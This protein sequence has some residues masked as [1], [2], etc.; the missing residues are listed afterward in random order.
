[1]LLAVL[2]IVSA[3][4]GGTGTTATPPAQTAEN[5]APV[6][7]GTDIPTKDTLVIG[8]A[9]FIETLDPLASTGD[10]NNALMQVYAFLTRMGEDGTPKLDLAE[11]MDVSEDGLTM[12]FVLKDA[13]FSNGDPITA[14]DVVFTLNRC[15]ESAYAKSNY[16]TVESFEAVDAKTVVIHLLTPDRTLPY[17]LATSNAGILNKASVEAAGDDYFL[18]PVASGPYKVESWVPGEKITFVA[19]ENYFGGPCAIKKIEWVPITDP[20]TM[21]IALQSGDID[22]AGRYAIDVSSQGVVESDPNLASTGLATASLI[23]LGFNTQKAPFDNPAVRQAISKAINKEE[24]VQMA[25][26]GRG[27]VAETCLPSNMSEYVNGVPTYPYDPEGAKA[28]LAAAGY[29][30]GFDMSI[31]ITSSLAKVAEVIQAQLAEVGIN[32]TLE[33]VESSALTSILNEGTYDSYFRQVGLT[34]YD[35]DGMVV[36]LYDSKGMFNQ[37]FY[38]N[39][40]LD[41]AMADAKGILDH[42]QMVAAYNEILKTANTDLPAIPLYYPTIYLSYKKDLNIPYFGS[43]AMFYVDNWSWAPG[44]Q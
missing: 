1:M 39:P 43:M 23:A 30:N 32:V 20:N 10:G 7:T 14:D 16:A 22:Y 19:N 3:C 41:K 31:A 2:M 15:K 6:A 8:H 28:A 27:E 33:T 9:A 37:S 24:L 42:G 21:L 25:L 11:S 44:A 36:K 5:G 13:K 40:Q 34:Y 17:V 18:N 38:S 4:S 26:E 12:T 29:P 35:P